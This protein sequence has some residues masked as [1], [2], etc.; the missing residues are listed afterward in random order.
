MS[1]IAFCTIAIAK[2]LQQEFPG[3]NGFSVQ[4]LWFMRQFYA[5]YID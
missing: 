2:D 3:R 5:K 1:L 4:N